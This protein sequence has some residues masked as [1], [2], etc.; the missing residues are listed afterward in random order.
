MAGELACEQ[1]HL[2]GVS[3]DDLGGEAAICRS[4]MGWNHFPRRL[5]RQDTGT[6]PQISEPV[7]NGCVLYLLLEKTSKIHSYNT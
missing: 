7:Y 5:C 2:F 1:A 4:G 6:K 3:R